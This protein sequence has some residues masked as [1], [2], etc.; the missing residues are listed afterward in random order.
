MG[1]D[2]AQKTLRDTCEKR[3]VLGFELVG[4]TGGGQSARG[5]RRGQIEPEGQVRLA[6]WAPGR[7]LAALHPLLKHGQHR[8]VESAPSSLV[9]KA[10]VREAVAQ[11]HVAAR[12]CRFDQLHQ[13]VAPRR[14]HKQRLCQRIHRVM[15]HKL[16]DLLGQRGPARFSGYQDRAPDAAKELRQG[17]D[18]G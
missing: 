18:L 13:M 12:Q 11:D 8:E 14:E 7:R 9:G 3:L 5:L 1:F 6:Y 16:A 15:Q 2:A 17:I 10:G 4:F